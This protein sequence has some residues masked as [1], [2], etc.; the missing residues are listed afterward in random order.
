MVNYEKV[1]VHGELVVGIG[2]GMATNENGF[3]VE[4]KLKNFKV[5]S[6]EI[7]MVVHVKKMACPQVENLDSC[8]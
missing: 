6:S 2:K 3:E 7:K 8:T 5:Q 4:F 1:K